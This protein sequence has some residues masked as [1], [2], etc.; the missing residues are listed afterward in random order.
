VG[1]IQ[2]IPLRTSS[3]HQNQVQFRA[4][5]DRKNGAMI[6]IPLEIDPDT[7]KWIYQK[8][9]LQDAETFDLSIA[10][11]AK[12]WAVIKH[13]HFL[14]GSPNL[15][16]RPIYKVRDDEKE[17]QLELQRRNIKRKA[18]TIAEGL[19]GEQLVDMARN[20]GIPP[21]RNSTNTLQLAVIRFAEKNPEKF[22]DIWDSPLRHETTVLKRA[23]SLGVIE[24]DVHGGYMYRSVSIGITEP[25]A[26]QFLKENPSLANS[27]DTLTKQKEDETVK[28]MAATAAAPIMDDKDVALLEMQKQIEFLTAQ[29][30]KLASEKLEEALGTDMKA[31]VTDPEHL[32][33]LEEAKKLKIKGYALMSKETLAQKVLEAAK[34]A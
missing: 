9:M 8:I 10:E 34:K 32:D 2:L 17:A 22:M 18:E 4:I 5:A 16:D 1:I 28:A 29:N 7:K 25:L 3:R 11:D 31:S 26:I 21:E 27:I 19:F 23:L 30:K 13:A 15:K 14:E 20:I 6:G 33:L 24:H 12:K